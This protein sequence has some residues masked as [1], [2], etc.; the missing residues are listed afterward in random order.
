MK[1]KIKFLLLSIAIGAISC[2][3]DDASFQN[4][5]SQGEPV[6]IEKNNR[7]SFDSSESIEKFIKG[8]EDEEFE[9][10]IKEFQED[11]FNSL[12][13]VFDE[14]D[15]ELKK[16][17]LAKR[18]NRINRDYKFSGIPYTAKASDLED[19]DLDDPLV[20]DDKFAS[21]LDEDRSIYVGDYL[22]VYTTKGLFKTHRK[23]EEEL[24]N[25]LD[26]YYE[27]GV[28]TEK[29]KNPNNLPVVPSKI[30][31][32]DDIIRAS[33][34]SFNLFANPVVN[35]TQLTPAIQLIQIDGCGGGGGGGGGGTGGGN[36]GGTSST[37]KYP[38][39]KK[40][41][42]GTCVIK[43][44]SIW[45]QIFGAAE[46]CND[47]YDSK[48]RV[49]TKFWNQNY[50]VYSSIGVSVKHQK[51]NWGIWD[52]SNATDFIELGINNASWT[53]DYEASHLNQIYNNFSTNTLVKYKGKTYNING[54]V[55]NDIPISVP[56]WPF[57][58]DDPLIDGLEIYMFGNNLLSG[59]DW[60]QAN[61]LLRDQAKSFIKKF[62]NLL[63][64]PANTDKLEVSGAVID[65]LNRKLT[66]TIVGRVERDYNDCC[67]T[68]YL[69]QNAF[70]GV[71]F[72][73]DYHNTSCS[74]TGCT[75]GGYDI[76]GFR[77]DVFNAK[78]Y[79]NLSIDFYGLARRDGSNYKGKRVIS[80]NIK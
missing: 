46:T 22:Y 78:D 79:K 69:D 60:K 1:T 56:N 14:N 51:K 73:I 19:E 35:T 15:T 11:G 30:Y 41:E 70:V 6:L 3:K 67:A 44:E 52:K 45:Q 75:S 20:I 63:E 71:K 58:G 61:R 5:E 54:S 43:S 23:N 28:V 18:L 4:S 65:P 32:C 12:S 59:A 33:E 16:A 74:G 53:Y 77:T 26:K 37:K 10:K 27:D 9:S 31:I 38:Y 13:P 8:Q 25:L 17:F 55:I 7:L 29:S 36:G 42:L 39:E 66:F 62:G 68:Y 64:G 49:K 2:S 48:R 50:L 34:S 76:N 24:M 21:I 40:I 72:N 47:Y 80:D 57:N